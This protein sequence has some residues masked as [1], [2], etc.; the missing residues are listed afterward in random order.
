MSGQAGGRVAASLRPWWERRPA[1]YSQEWRELSEA[2]YAPERDETALERGIVSLRVTVPTEVFGDLPLVV[3]YPDFYPHFRPQVAA[4]TLGFADLPHHLHPFGRTLCLLGRGSEHWHAN[5]TASR[6]IREQLAPALTAGRSA[7]APEAGVEQAQAEPFH[8][9]PEY[10]PAI[11]LVPPGLELDSEQQSGR[12]SVR[13]LEPLSLPTRSF[14]RGVMTTIRD[15]AG[16]VLAEA[17]P[18]FAPPSAPLVHGRWRRLAR[19][20]VHPTG[21]EFLK[22]LARLDPHARF[23]PANTVDGGE[24]KLWGVV[25]PDEVGHRCRG[26]AWMFVAEAAYRPSPP[27]PAHT[28]KKPRNQKGRRR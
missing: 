11:V 28:P 16:N 9:Y 2:G 23:A 25:Y 17:G 22:S 14:A 4:P 3:T 26:D 5:W 1:C 13:L 27:R 18:S 8:T 20:I 7:D 21:S 24:L 10:P 19:P 6:L 12:F 15:A